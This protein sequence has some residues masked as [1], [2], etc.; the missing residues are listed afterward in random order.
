MALIVCRRGI[1]SSWIALTLG[2]WVALTLRW[3]IAL[4]R[5]TI[6]LLLR[7][8]SNRRRIWLINARHLLMW[9]YR[10]WLWTK[11]TIPFVHFNLVLCLQT[12][13]IN[14]EE[15]F[16]YNVISFACGWINC[17]P[18]CRHRPCKPKHKAES[19]GYFAAILPRSFQCGKK[20][21]TYVQ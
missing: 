15:I 20:E 1:T 2:W 5:I 6:C 17:I 9:G 4:R 16:R 14:C 13:Q 10:H 21:N 19:V 11:F 3:W 18:A 7:W 12:I 8:I